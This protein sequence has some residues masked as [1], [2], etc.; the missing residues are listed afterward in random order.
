MCL[1]RLGHQ[2]DVFTRWDDPSQPQQVQWQAGIRVIHIQ[3]GPWH[4][5]PKRICSLT[6]MNLRRA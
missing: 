1:A 5:W 2:V 3:A 4:R 6:W